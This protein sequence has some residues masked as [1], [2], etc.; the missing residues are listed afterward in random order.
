MGPYLLICVIIAAIA[1]KQSKNWIL[2][3]FLSI[4]LTPLAGV[5]ALILMKPDKQKFENNAVNSGV[6]RKCP[7][8]AEVIKSEAVVCRY[9][10]KEL[11]AIAEQQEKVI[12]IPGRSRKVGKYTQYY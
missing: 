2:T 5:L 7:Y 12:P 4:F 3:L 9:C 10:H 1:Y 6:F 11:E 8:C